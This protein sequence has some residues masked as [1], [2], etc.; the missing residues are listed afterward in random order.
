MK[1]DGWINPTD[2]RSQ[3]ETNKTLKSVN[4]DQCFSRIVLRSTTP[5]SDSD[6]YPKLCQHFV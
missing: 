6:S 4:H 5:D 3:E 1:T 2:H